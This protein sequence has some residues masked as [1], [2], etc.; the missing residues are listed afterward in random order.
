M[1]HYFL[2][3]SFRFLLENMPIKKYIFSSFNNPLLFWKSPKKSEF[4][5][6]LLVDF[7]GIY[8]LVDN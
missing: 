8:H 4:Q 7:S 1:E 2:K 3:F 6:M 5:R